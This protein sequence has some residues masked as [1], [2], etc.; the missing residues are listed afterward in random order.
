MERTLFSV[1]DDEGR[2]SLE[3]ELTICG[4]NC[5]LD[6]KNSDSCVWIRFHT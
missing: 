6:G 1:G 3:S 2:P 5:A 4:T